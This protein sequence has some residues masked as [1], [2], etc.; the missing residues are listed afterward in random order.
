MQTS[1]LSPDDIIM[2]G[3]LAGT[4]QSANISTSEPTSNIAGARINTP[5]M[6]HSL[7]PSRQALAQRAVSKLWS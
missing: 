6:Y 1:A 3:L 5:V 7:L 2:L 4:G